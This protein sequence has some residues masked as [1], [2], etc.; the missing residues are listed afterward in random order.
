MKHG[1]FTELAKF[2][3][4][5]PGYSRVVL[6]CLKNHVF[7]TLGEGNVADVGAGTGKLTENLAEIGLSGFAVEP[8]EAMRVEAAKNAGGGG[9]DFLWSE[10]TA[11][12]TGLNDNCVNW[13]LM[14]SSFHWADSSLAVKEFYRI[15]VPGGFFTA[16]WNPRDIESSEL[17]QRIEEVVYAEVPAM[18]RVSSG[19]TVSTEEMKEKLLTGGYFKDILFIEAPHVEV[20]T[21]ERYMNTWKSVNDIQVQAGEDGFRRILEEI[22]KIISEYDEIE[23][24]YRSRSWTVQSCK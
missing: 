24:P 6:E 19:R 13:V 9:K 5:R 20:M 22:G 7:N 23:V 14:G 17:H 8:N 16:I 2:Y 1:D 21:K 12:A 15:L 3:V 18:K 10:G 4:N 11:E